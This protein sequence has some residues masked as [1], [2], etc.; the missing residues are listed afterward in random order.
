MILVLI[1]IVRSLSYNL[2][3]KSVGKIYFFDH[4]H[5]SAKATRASLLQLKE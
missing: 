2:K 3:Q 4:T 5:E 1:E